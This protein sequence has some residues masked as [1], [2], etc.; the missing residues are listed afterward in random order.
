MF[1]LFCFKTDLNEDVIKELEYFIHNMPAQSVKNI[2]IS[3]TI[4]RPHEVGATTKAAI[5]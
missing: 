4:P 3:L 5:S 2:P 1:F